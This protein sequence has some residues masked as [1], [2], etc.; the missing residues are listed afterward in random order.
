MLSREGL[1]KFSIYGIRKHGK[2]SQIERAIEEMAELISELQHFKRGA[3][4]D[5]SVVKE[6]ADVIITSNT[7]KI[8]FDPSGKIDAIIREKM[9][10]IEKE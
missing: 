4:T 3:S 2:E 7:L 5:E 6:I 8:I 10:K 9:K 1:D